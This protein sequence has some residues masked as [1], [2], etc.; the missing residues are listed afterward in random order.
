MLVVVVFGV[1]AGGTGVGGYR[2]EIEECIGFTPTVIFGRQ[3]RSK[4]GFQQ[5]S[6]FPNKL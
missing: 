4:V 2:E 1:G 6:S 3:D 5:Y